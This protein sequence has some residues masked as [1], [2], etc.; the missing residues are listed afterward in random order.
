MPRYRG[1]II[2]SPWGGIGEDLGKLLAALLFGKDY[3]AAQKAK[4][5]FTPIMEKEK[6]TGETAPGME[7]LKAQG[8]KKSARI[9]KYYKK[10]TGEEVP[11][12]SGSFQVP[13]PG[14]EPVT[15]PGLAPSWPTSQADYQMRTAA[16]LARGTPS[17]N[18]PPMAKDI[19]DQMEFERKTR[20]L[21]ALNRIANL[22]IPEEQKAVFAKDLG[23]TY[24]TPPDKKYPYNQPATSFYT[25]FEMTIPEFETMRKTGTP[26]ERKPK[27]RFPTVRAVT[28]PD[29][30]IRIDRYYDLYAYALET[31]A[32]TAEQYE[33]GLKT[34]ID[35]DGRIWPSFMP[36]Q[37]P[38]TSPNATSAR[39]IGRAIGMLPP[40]VQRILDSGTPAERDALEAKW[41]QALGVE[42]ARKEAKSWITM[43]VRMG[44]EKL[45]RQYLE[46]L[47]RSYGLTPP[48]ASSIGAKVW[49]AIQS[50]VTSADPKNPPTDEELQGIIE[51]ELLPFRTPAPTSPFGFGGPPP[52]PTKP[53]AKGSSTVTADNWNAIY[54][55]PEEKKKRASQ[56]PPPTGLRTR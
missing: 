45:G 34:L 24:E 4:E 50:L 43:Y 21:D 9:Q 46:S 28:N 55:S 53:V 37:R 14:V 35:S 6:V 18:L 33:T 38:G 1:D 5:E 52:V 31:G 15:Q 56:T 7:Y 51:R 47:I 36:K 49:K 22:P 8:P 12:P 42:K 41:T 19:A 3:Q 10:Q 20:P 30:G 27:E 32:I 2:E 13:V 40:E 16:E 29:L 11:Y 48:V 25:Q 17:A 54:L 44:K 39:E 26:P 23:V